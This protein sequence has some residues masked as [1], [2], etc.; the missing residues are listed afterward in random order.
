MALVIDDTE[1]SRCYTMDRF[2]RMDDALSVRQLLDRCRVVLRSM[3]D[4]E[5]DLL[6]Q[7]RDT[8][9]KVM[10]VM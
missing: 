9:C 1:L 10:E 5:G 4:L 8:F 2:G 7:F 6:G 3:A